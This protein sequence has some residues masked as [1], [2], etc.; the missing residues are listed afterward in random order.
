ME[1]EKTA[2]APDSRIWRQSCETTRLR[3]CA[4]G[5]SRLGPGVGARRVEYDGVNAMAFLR[6][7]NPVDAGPVVHARRAVLRIPAS[8]DYA[9]WA[10][11]RA[12]SRTFLTPW[13]PAWTRDELSRSAFRRRIRH[14]NQ[15]LR[16]ESGFA[17]FMFE[18]TAGQLVGGVSLSNIR[19]GVTESCVLGYWVGEPYAGQGYMSE[20]VSSVLPFVFETLR[21]HRLEAACL[22]GNTASIKVLEK[23]RFC[24]EGLAKKYLKING[25]WQDHIL[26]A[27]LRDDWR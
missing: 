8:S 15:E 19:R 16:D 11:L 26:F 18:R 4:T 9:A 10:E 12:R 21:L 25:V 14:Y 6:A 1:P 5:I 3:V 27:L 20:A 2:K 24:H 22:P 7:T 23:N 17:F 13:E